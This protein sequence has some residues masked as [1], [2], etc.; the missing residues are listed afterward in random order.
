MHA[1]WGEIG[2]EAAEAVRATLAAGGRVIPVGTTALRLLETAATG[3]GTIVPW[4]G[5]TDIFIRPGH[6]FRIADGLMTNFHLP[7]STLLD[8][9]LG[10]DGAGAHP[11][12]LCPRHRGALPLLLLWRLVAAAAVRPTRGGARPMLYVLKTSWALLLGVL[13]LLIG[14][15]LQGT[16]LGIRGGI[17]GYRRG[18]DVAG[19]ERL[20]RRLSR[21]VAA[22]DGADRAASAT[23]GCSPPSAR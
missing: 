20:L 14:N 7:R 15:G 5:E 4:R 10:A 22:G 6:G 8:A 11:R 12:D 16:L 18:D 17:E 1:E 2:A 23:S 19:D 13:L 9:G 21:R 3:P